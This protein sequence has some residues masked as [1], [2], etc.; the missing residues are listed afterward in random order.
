MLIARKPWKPLRITLARKHIQIPGPCTNV[1]IP[2]YTAGRRWTHRDKQI[3]KCQC[4]YRRFEVAPEGARD[5]LLHRPRNL[6]YPVTFRNI[7]SSQCQRSDY[8][9]A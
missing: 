6:V 7:N 4:S 9:M 1:N 8:L 5:D 3:T 2:K